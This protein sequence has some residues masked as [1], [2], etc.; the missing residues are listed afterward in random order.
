MEDIE[1]RLRQRAAMD[2]STGVFVDV[3]RRLCAEAADMIGTLRQKLDEAL[4]I[5]SNA[6][7]EAKRQCDLK[8][9][10]QKRAEEAEKGLAFYKD[11]RNFR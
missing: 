5:M 4:D 10:A 1:T 8:L 11:H 3:D 9:A 2:A 6:V 7:D